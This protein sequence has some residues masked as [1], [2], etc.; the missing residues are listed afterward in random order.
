MHAA[1]LFAACID[2]QQSSGPLSMEREPSFDFADLSGPVYDALGVDMTVSC[3]VQ[4]CHCGHLRTRRLAELH[5]ILYGNCACVQAS[6]TEI[7]NAYRRLARVGRGD[8]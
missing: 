7:V 6:N 4:R 8:I 3:C 1:S 2:R 5:H